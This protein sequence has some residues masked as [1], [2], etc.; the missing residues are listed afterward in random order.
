M[1]K[2]TKNMPTLE[3]EQ[4][5]DVK[6]APLIDIEISRDKDTGEVK[7]FIKSEKIGNFIKS[8]T[9][10]SNVTSVAEASTSYPRHTHGKKFS[11]AALPTEFH[12]PN[13][14]VS[15]LLVD[16]K[17]I[18]FMFRDMGLAEGT[19]YNFSDAMIPAD[20]L[21]KWKDQLANTAKD[22]FKKYVGLV[23]YKVGI[24]VELPEV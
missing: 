5:A 8:K 7:V 14:N 9:S 4:A 16:P 24:D 12:Q 23:S 3:K 22:F 21:G 10:N 18:T 13:V 17:Y 1:R 15:D 6:T 19:T 2:K 20:I 11:K